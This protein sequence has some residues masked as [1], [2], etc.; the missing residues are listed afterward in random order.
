MKLIIKHIIPYILTAFGILLFVMEIKSQNIELYKLEIVVDDASNLIE[1]YTFPSDSLEKSLIQFE[2]DSLVN[3][4]QARAHLEAS[5]DSIQELPKKIVAHFHPGVQFKWAKLKNGNIEKAFLTGTGYRISDFDNQIFQYPDLI[6][7][8]NA[9]LDKAENLGFP[10]AAIYLDSI[11]IVKDQ[12]Q[13]VLMLDKNASIVFGEVKKEGNLKISDTYLRNYLGIKKGEVYDKSKVLDIKNKLNDLAFVG[14]EKDP[15]VFFKGEEAEINLFLKKRNASRFD[16]LFGL[17]PT[18]AIGENENRYRFTITFDADL[19]NQLGWGERIYMEFQNLQ[20]QTQE[21]K[22]GFNYPYILDLPFGADFKFNLYK[23]DTSFLNIEYDLGVQYLFGAGN[24]LK[25]FVSNRSTNLIS[26]NEARLISSKILPPTLDVSTSNVGLEYQLNKLDY[27]FNPRKGLDLNVQTRLGL[28]RI[29][30]NTDITSLIDPNNLD[31]DF[32]TIYDTLNL[33][34]FQSKI[35]VNV[36]YYFPI[37]KRSTLKVKNHTGFFLSEE[38]AFENEQYRIGGNRILRGFDDESIFADLFSVFTLE[39]R[40]LIARNSFIAV[41]SDYAIIE[42]QINEDAYSG[43]A[44]SIGAG[45]TFDTKV[46]IFGINYAVGRTNEIPFDLRTAKIHLG[47]V[48]LF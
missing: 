1:E 9:I 16:F 46:G 39:Y 27:R 21:L 17:L 28:R 5:I 29:R 33:K 25:T 26:I 7:L 44:W 34:S 31:F 32:S 3:Y 38:Q 42:N 35:D 23:R 13:G 14:I 15:S 19:H 43:S 37:M 30:E 22:L 47:Y 41:F 6:K 20:A 2:L 18:G 45:L 12:I 8:Q 40:L 36:S 24:Y 11:H 10:F 48:S 4:Y